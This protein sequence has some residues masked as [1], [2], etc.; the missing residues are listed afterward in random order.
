MTADSAEHVA[1]VKTLH[2]AA[3]DARLLQRPTDVRRIFEQLT[4]VNNQLSGTFPHLHIFF[5]PPP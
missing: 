5:Q 2:V 4:D 3:E 1:S